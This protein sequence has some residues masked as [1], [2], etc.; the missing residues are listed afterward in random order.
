MLGIFFVTYKLSKK[1]TGDM[2]KEKL[3]LAIVPLV[4]ISACGKTDPVEEILNKY[5]GDY[6]LVSV[7]L[8]DY[9]SP[10]DLNG[11]GSSHGGE[12]VLEELI[13]LLNYREQLAMF[14]PGIVYSRKGSFGMSIPSQMIEAQGEA[15]FSLESPINVG[16]ANSYLLLPY[17]ADLTIDGNNKESW[18]SNQHEYADNDRMISRSYAGEPEI[19]SADKDIIV[20]RLGK[21]LFYDFST[22]SLINSGAVYTFKHV[23]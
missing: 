15:P 11:D 16:N 21:A 19:V 5:K 17:S 23:R 4:L 18:T 10:V 8:T 22:E 1:Y 12:L 20:F 6:E 14:T 9:D 2:K 3:F 13:S 7:K